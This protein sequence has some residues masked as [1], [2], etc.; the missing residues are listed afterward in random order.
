MAANTPRQVALRTSI[1]LSLSILA[2]C[3]VYSWIG[4]GKINPLHA[5]VFGVLTFACCYFLISNSIE[6]FIYDRIKVIYKTI[7]RFKS[8][9]DQDNT[10]QM[11]QDVLEC[12]ECFTAIK[13]RL[14]T[15]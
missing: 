3:L 8:S 2:L 7:H 13:K 6:R 12:K 11:D 5:G 15:C 10:I 4:T 1:I 14:E 9:P